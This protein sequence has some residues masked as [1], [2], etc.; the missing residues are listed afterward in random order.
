MLTSNL[1]F[2]SLT[3]QTDHQFDVPVM[4]G[5]KWY[6]SKKDLRLLLPGRRAVRVFQGVLLCC[7][8]GYIKHV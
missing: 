2:L 3:E 7:I 6:S 5:H 4:K 1:L 8:L